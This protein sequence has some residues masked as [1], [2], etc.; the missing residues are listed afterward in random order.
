MTMGDRS[1]VSNNTIRESSGGFDAVS[2]VLVLRDNDKHMFCSNV[3]DNN[4]VSKPLIYVYQEDLG[5]VSSTLVF[6]N[7]TA[8]YDAVTANYPDV[9]MRALPTLVMVPTPAGPPWGHGNLFNALLT[10]LP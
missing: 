8:S 4:T 3:M 10:T 7:N 9:E 1:V 5:G 2:V 6:T